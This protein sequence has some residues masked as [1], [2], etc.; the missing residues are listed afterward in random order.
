MA[1]DTILGILLLDLQFLFYSHCL[2]FY[3]FENKQIMTCDV[4]LK[5]DN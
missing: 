3:Q 1:H 4:I 2:P 5:F